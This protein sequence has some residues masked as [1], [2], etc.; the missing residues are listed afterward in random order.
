MGIY[1]GIFAK[2]IETVGGGLTHGKLVLLS[3]Y[4]NKKF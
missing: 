4:L 1:D 3:A 2:N